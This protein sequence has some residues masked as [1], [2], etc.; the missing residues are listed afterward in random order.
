MLR[1]E[2]LDRKA[3]G[4][5]TPKQAMQLVAHGIDPREMYY[6]AA[7]ELLRELKAAKRS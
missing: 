7:K 5:C 6:D 3:V 1:E 2:L 4:L